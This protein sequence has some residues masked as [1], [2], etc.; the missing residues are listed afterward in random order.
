MQQE[1]ISFQEFSSEEEAAEMAARLKEAGLFFKLDKTPALLDSTFI[2]TSLTPN[3]SI[4]LLPSDFTKARETLDEYYK[5]QAESADM[6]Y[7]LFTLTD[8]ELNEILF[9][10]EEWGPYNYHL[11]NKILRE[12]KSEIDDESLKKKAAERVSLFLRPEKAGS[13]FYLTGYIFV[14]LGLLSIFYIRL[15]FFPFLFWFPFLS[16]VIGRHM[17]SAKKILPDGQRVFFYQKKDRE[18]GMI[19]MYSG[20]AV[21][22]IKISQLVFPNF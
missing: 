3:I 5:K 9:N 1:L 20:L 2:G 22:L 19:I 14:V 18:H 6:D 21:F 16:V 12:R 17:F 11:A 13:S 7:F 10:P 4:K 15:N 8:K